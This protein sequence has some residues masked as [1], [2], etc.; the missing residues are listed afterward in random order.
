MRLFGRLLG[1]FLIL[2]TVGSFGLDL[3][4]LVQSGRLRFS[5]LGELWF[6]LDSASLNTTQAAIERYVSPQLWDW[7]FAPVLQW[8]AVFVFLVPG[9]VLLVLCGRSRSKRRFY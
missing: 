2:L 9:I 4:S 7:I 5:P 6:R 1:Y 3:L 8:P